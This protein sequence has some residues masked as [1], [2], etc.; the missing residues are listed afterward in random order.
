MFYLGKEHPKMTNKNELL[1]V[2]GELSEKQRTK[3]ID[4]LLTLN[5]QYISEPLLPDPQ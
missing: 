2:V 4:Y 5:N 3:L 1:N